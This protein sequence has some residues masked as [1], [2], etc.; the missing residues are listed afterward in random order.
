MVKRSNIDQIANLQD[1]QTLYRFNVE[2]QFPS[3]VTFNDHNL[4]VMTAEL[5]KRSIEEMSASPA[6]GH[7]VYQDGRTAYD[8]FTLT[9]IE[10]TSGIVQDM[11]HSWLGLEWETRTGLQR[12]K[13][14]KVAQV[15]LTPQDGQDNITY[16]YRL[17][18]AWITNYDLGTMDG[19]A[20]ELMKPTMTLRYDYFID[21]PLSGA[22]GSS[23]GATADVS[24]QII[25]Y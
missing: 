11:I 25:G 24:A 5:P 7:T 1:F 13:R 18:N 6:G 4:Q 9:F 3:G 15:I 14:E 22:R 2:I 16:S 19:G 8:P 23:S 17:I 21:T 10:K 12:P 20:S